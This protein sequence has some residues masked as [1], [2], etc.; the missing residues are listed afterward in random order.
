MLENLR[1][2]KLE[3]DN[4]IIGA[5]SAFINIPINMLIMFIFRCGTP[6]NASVYLLG[7]DDEDSESDSSEESSGSN[8]LMES[9]SQNT[10]TESESEFSV[11]TSSEQLNKAPSAFR[12]AWWCIPIAWTLVF[13]KSTVS[14]YVTI[15]YGLSYGHDK[16]MAWLRSFMMSATSDIGV[17]QPAKVAITVCV[18]IVILKSPVQP[19]TN[20][21]CMLG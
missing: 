1:S 8:D 3:L 2:Y 17:F 20:L 14:S 5:Q 12:L 21:A 13:V 16:S 15:M 19:M 4:F 7:G 18:F 11:S 6:K 10:K 9:S